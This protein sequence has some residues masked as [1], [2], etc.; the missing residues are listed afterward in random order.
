MP[1][2]NS[3]SQLFPQFGIVLV[4]E[5]ISTRLLFQ[6]VTSKIPKGSLT[7]P[8]SAKLSQRAARGEKYTF[9]VPEG[10][11]IAYPVD[12]KPTGRY[13]WNLYFEP[14]PHTSNNLINF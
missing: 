12:Q 1:R 14:K 9:L 5:K 13:C 11:W 8:S 3:S 4:R 2:S 6:E 10:V 7:L